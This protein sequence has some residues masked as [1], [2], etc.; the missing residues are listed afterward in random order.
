VGV[1]R[2]MIGHQTFEVSQTMGWTFTLKVHT[3]TLSHFH[4]ESSAYKMAE[5]L[6][7]EDF[8][9]EIDPNL[10]QYAYA[11]HESG[12]TSSTTMKYW[13]KQDFQGLA[14]YIPQGHWWLILNMITQLCTPE[15]KTAEHRSSFYVKENRWK[16]EKDEFPFHKRHL[17]SLYW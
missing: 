3:F 17:S 14:V 12:F 7:I 16:C 13:W 6:D 5:R 8:F 11:F 2:G 4:T 1:K 10:C 9:R 15:V